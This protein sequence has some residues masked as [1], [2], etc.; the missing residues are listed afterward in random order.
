M[1]NKIYK[2]NRGRFLPA[3]RYGS[4][5]YVCKRKGIKLNLDIDEFIDFIYQKCFYC[6]K[7]PDFKHPN[8]IDRKNQNLGYDL[9]N[10]VPCCT[11]CNYMKRKM[12]DKEFI[13]KC[14][15]ISNYTKNKF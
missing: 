11:E 12:S 8:G 15:Q 5:K 9:D 2:K 7:I 13:E 4:Y 3:Y 10:C 1:Y 6:G 14:S